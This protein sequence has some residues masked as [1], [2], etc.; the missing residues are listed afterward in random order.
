M[1]QHCTSRWQIIAPANTFENFFSEVPV[2]SVLKDK[3]RFLQKKI[4]T[5]SAAKLIGTKSGGMLYYFNSL[6][7]KKNPSP[8][9]AA[10]AEFVFWFCAASFTCLWHRQY[11]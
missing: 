5:G 11:C 3:T 1:L 6:L 4:F 9:P 7:I 10:G 8:Q 2:F